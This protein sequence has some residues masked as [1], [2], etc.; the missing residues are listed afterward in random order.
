VQVLVYHRGQGQETIS[1]MFLMEKIDIVLTELFELAIWIVWLVLGVCRKSIDLKSHFRWAVWLV[2]LLAASAVKVD[3]GTTIDD[4][5]ILLRLPTP[6]VNIT[7]PKPRT[8]YVPLPSGRH[9]PRPYSMTKSL[10]RSSPSRLASERTSGPPRSTHYIYPSFF[11]YLFFHTY[12]VGLL[13]I[14]WRGRV[15]AWVVMPG[16][17]IH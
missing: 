1:G 5:E 17:G 11:F 7:E 3:T 10:R 8:V 2:H 13:F 16:T 6:T 9:L 14:P 12:L 15:R 4:D